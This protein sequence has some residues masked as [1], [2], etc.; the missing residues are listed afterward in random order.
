MRNILQEGT[1]KNLTKVAFAAGTNGLAK[2]HTLTVKEANTAILS[3]AQNATRHIGTCQEEADTTKVKQMS[4]ELENE[5]K[6]IIGDEIHIRKSAVH[7]LIPQEAWK[8]IMGDEIADVCLVKIKELLELW[9]YLPCC[10]VS[11]MHEPT[12]FREKKYVCEAQKAEAFERFC[13]DLGINPETKSSMN[14]GWCKSYPH[15]R[16]GEGLKLVVK[17]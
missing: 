1:G 17:E 13:K 12:H 16:K 5:L 14:C 10:H 8:E 6:E 9:A 4:N 11:G 7:A 15:Y 3:F 2:S